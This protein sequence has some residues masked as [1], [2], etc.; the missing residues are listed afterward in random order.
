VAQAIDL[1]LYALV[2]LTVII[3]PAGTAVLFIGLT[4]HDTTA[5]R[6]SQARR[7]CFVAF[8]VLALF[9]LGGELLLTRLGI[10]LAAMKVAGGI[11]LFLTAADMVT[12]KGVLRAT[13]EERE[14]AT[15]TEE[16]IAV[17][18]LA[19]PL[20]AGPGAM[21]TMVVLH[22]RAAGNTLAIT[23]IEVALVLVLG[24]TLVALLLARQ[25]A[26]LLGV[27]GA[28]VIGRVLGVLLAG[29]A[30]QLVLDGV[31]QGWAG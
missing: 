4:P 7:A 10:S 3:D 21:T 25:V 26:K 16:D 20:L 15:R 24:A 30:A 18:P 11:L 9:G 29:L 1:F 27:T 2:A 12:A 22:A 8:A 13:T 19:I 17:F 14:A 6:T 23:A 31:R 5:E 28:T